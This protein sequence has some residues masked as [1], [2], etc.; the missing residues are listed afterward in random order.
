VPRTTTPGSTPGSLPAGLRWAIWLLLAEALAI[1]AIVAF[2]LYDN[3]PSTS[4]AHEARGAAGPVGYAVVLALLGWQLRARR[5][6]ARGAGIVTQ[7]LLL[8]IGYTIAG[9]GAPAL[10][11]PMILVGLAGAG[12]LLARSSREALGIH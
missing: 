4:L 5:A 3:Y 11:V 8:P 2:E 9:G 1:L 6:W 12:L 7:L 10:G